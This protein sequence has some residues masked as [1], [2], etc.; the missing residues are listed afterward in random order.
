[1]IIAW[2]SNL[3]WQD[4]QNS[5]ELMVSV[6]LSSAGSQND[7]THLRT[8]TLAAHVKQVKLFV[9]FSS[10]FM[11]KIFQMESQNISWLETMYEAMFS[12]GKK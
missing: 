6:F 12:K 7:L 11:L 2:I 9:Y 4:K 8:S 3:S 5:A 1:M 10:R